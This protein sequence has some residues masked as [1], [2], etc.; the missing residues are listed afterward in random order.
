MKCNNNRDK[1]CSLLEKL[2]NYTVIDF[3]TTGRYIN[4]C[5][6]IEMSA[7]RVRDNEIEG[8][9]TTFVN[10]EE[11]IP[12]EIVRLTGITDEMVEP[13]PTIKECIEE[14]IEF[15]G[16]DI[17]IG[18]NI[19]S[20]DSN[21][22]YDN[23]LS[24]IGVKVQ[25]DYVDTLN[26][27]KRCGIDLSNYKLTTIQEYF[28][29]TND[30]QH[31][32]LSDCV[33]THECY[34]KMKPLFSCNAYVPKASGKTSAVNRKSFYNNDTQ[35]IL[36]LKGLLTG[37]T[38]DNVLTKDEVM[39]LRSW[40]DNNRQLSGTYPFD[41]VIEEIEKALMDGV[42]EKHELE[43]MLDVFKSLLDP[44][45]SFSENCSCSDIS[46]SGKIV[47][48]TGEFEKFD[49]R[50]DVEKYL[51][52]KGAIIKN[53]V[54]KSLDYLIVGGCGSGN[55]SCGNYGNKVKKVLEMQKKGSDVKIIKEEELMA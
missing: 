7:V 26:F 16:E 10:P 54:I 2:D 45:E 55:W 23:A 31:R 53:S 44:V 14:F 25:N 46:L 50:A 6:I 15:I 34:Q 21:I 24:S 38:C 20:F 13:A 27:V 3:E 48:L 11:P 5:K 17:L 40:V 52:E 22:L 33:A 35:N 47:C 1:G 4:S 28:D 9:Y 19:S 49:S 51:E 39:A 18:H 8:V 29:I 42:L 37:I 43:Y 30:S 41:V 12:D 32:S 36:M